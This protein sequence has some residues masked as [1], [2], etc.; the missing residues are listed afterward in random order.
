MAVGVMAVAAIAVGAI[1][2]T[3]AGVAVAPVT[4]MT[5]VGAA[6]GAQA[7]RARDR[8][9]KKVPIRVNRYNFCC[10]II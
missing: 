4:G 8:I 6:A 9:T 1:V 7:A 5:E 10:F 3:G 2:L